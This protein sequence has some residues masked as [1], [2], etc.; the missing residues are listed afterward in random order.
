MFG[1]LTINL[2]YMEKLVEYALI[3]FLFT[4]GGTLEQTTSV[5]LGFKTEK[6]CEEAGEKVRENAIKGANDLGNTRYK[7]QIRFICVKTK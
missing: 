7:P 1:N 3:L 5:N 6:F 4:Q 2:K